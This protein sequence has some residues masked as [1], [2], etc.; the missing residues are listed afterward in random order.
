MENK[1]AKR[2]S[3]SSG[4]RLLPSGRSCLG[5]VRGAFH[6]HLDPYDDHCLDQEAEKNPR[7]PLIGWGW[8][9]EMTKEDN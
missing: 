2:W 5:K 8:V 3:P 1:R 4:N 7:S 6:H 9:K